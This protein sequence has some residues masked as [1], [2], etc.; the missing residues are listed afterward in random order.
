MAALCRTKASRFTLEDAYTLEQIEAM[1]E[2][3][4]AELVIP[5]ERIFEDLPKVTLEPFFSRLASA[6][7]EIYLSKIGA[8]FGLGQRVRL[9]NDNSFF[10]LGEVREFECGL[11]IKPI[12]LFEL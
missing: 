2:E 7:A 5:V 8:D 10:A 12:K 6:G 9:Y 1:P 4:R 3:K 11:A